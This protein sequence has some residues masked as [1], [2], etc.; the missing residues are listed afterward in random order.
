M[1][2]PTRYTQP[3][4]DNFPS[5][6]YRLIELVE[7]AWLSPETPNGLKLDEW[8]QWLLI[9]LLERYPADH[10]TRPNRLRYRQAVISMGRQNGKSVLGAILGLYGL[11]LHEHGPQV[12]SLASSVDQATIIYDRVLY[13]IRNNPALAKRFKRATET[14]GIVT[15]DGGGKYMVKPAKE[16]ALQGI[17]VSLCLFDELH[18]ANKGMWSASVFGTSQRND[19]IVIGITTAGDETSETLK[20]LYTFGEQAINGSSALEQFGF[21]CWE[22]PAGSNVDDPEAIK[23]ANPAIECGRIPLDRVLSDLQT[24]PENEARRYRLNQFVS[25]TSESWLPSEFFNVAAGSGVQNVEGAIIALDRTKS[26]EYLTLAAAHKNGDVIE[27]ELVATLVQPREIDVYHLLEKMFQEKKIRAVALDGQMFPDLAKRLK[28]HGYKTYELWSKEVAAACS[29]TF[30]LFANG[31]IR[32][33][34][35]PLLRQQVGHGVAKY[36]GETW[37]I[38]RRESRGDI[39]ALMATMFGI[40]VA[41]IVEGEVIQFF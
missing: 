6:G 29:T 25:S 31:S 2:F 7:R 22:A 8:Q 3:L 39:D 9:H 16:A 37:R 13:V 38:S 33:N 23:A 19:G 21:F 27:T 32:H 20:E 17:P 35:D 4:S 10:P 15:A 36:T 30:S 24:L 5:D 18:L 41:T 1:Q 34:N 40:Y 28:T 12:L 11:L 14:R 26:W